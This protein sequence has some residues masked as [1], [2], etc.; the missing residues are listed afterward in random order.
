M[1][2]LMIVAAA[3]AMI[4]SVEAAG[5]N[6]QATLRTTQARAGVNTFAVCNLGVD[7]AGNF[8]YTDPAVV[9]LQRALPAAFTTKS[10]G[11]NVVPAFVKE[12][13]GVAR[14][15]T[16]GGQPATDAIRAL[17]A[18]YR[19]P[20]AGVFCEQVNVIDFA[21]CYRVAGSRVLTSQ[22]TQANCCAAGVAGDGFI[23]KAP[24]YAADSLFYGT[25][26][27]PAGATA[28]RQLFDTPLLQRFGWYENT[29]ANKVE[30]YAPVQ[31]AD[32]RGYLAGQGT[33]RAI[34]PA[35][36]VQ[37]ITGNIV[38][39]LAAPQC[40]SCCVPATASVAFDCA[41]AA[42]ATQLPR[43]AAYGTFRLIFNAAL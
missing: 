30:I 31:V 32:F 2:K 11:G 40:T 33:M 34:T 15:V 4:G 12:A 23:G 21:N 41:N 24:D 1:K 22:F 5:Y 37:T 27:I 36:I 26:W 18:V 8:W 43:T 20:S 14:I 35:P 42:V 10:V 25:T 29:R 38:G 7:A 13:N 28:N 9:A 19:F 6:F 16:L 17:A 39:T 3:A